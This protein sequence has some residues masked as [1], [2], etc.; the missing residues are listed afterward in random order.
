MATR[1]SVGIQLWNHI[2]K[3]ETRGQSFEIRVNR[4]RG[5]SVFK[6][7]LPQEGN[8]R[9]PLNHFQTTFRRCKNSWSTM[10]MH[11]I[12]CMRNVGHYTIV[13]CSFLPIISSVRYDAWRNLKGVQS[14]SKLHKIPN[15]EAR[16]STD[17]D[18]A[19]DWW[20]VKIKGRP[21]CR[22]DDCPKSRNSH[23]ASS[24][25]RIKGESPQVELFF[26]KFKDLF[27]SKFQ[28]G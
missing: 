10:Q 26:H 19:W 11:T 21:W 1:M 25:S 20:K 16:H 22:L 2:Y 27:L 14:A 18:K 5:H 3:K 4:E 12:L 7:T 15:R 23:Q 8:S 13:R 9:E 6:E 28:I 24:S 17:N